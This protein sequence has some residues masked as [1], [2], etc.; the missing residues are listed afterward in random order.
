MQQSGQGT[1][2]LSRTGMATIHEYA[3]FSC[4]NNDMPNTTREKSNRNLE[5]V[6]PGLHEHLKK[7]KIGSKIAN[8]PDCAV[9]GYYKRVP[10]DYFKVKPPKTTIKR[11]PGQTSEF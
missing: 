3:S 5:L 10:V 2:M 8:D 9:P 11:K 7:I 6:I 4:Q 1:S